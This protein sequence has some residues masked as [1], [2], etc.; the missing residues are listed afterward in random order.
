MTGKF[1]CAFRPLKAFKLKCLNLDKWTNGLKIT[2]LIFFDRL[3]STVCVR[4]FKSNRQ[5]V[6]NESDLLCDRFIKGSRIS[7][8]KMIEMVPDPIE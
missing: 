7:A 1:V 8:T 3:F 5:Y 6:S 2:D 4:G